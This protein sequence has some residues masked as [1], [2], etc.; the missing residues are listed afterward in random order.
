MKVK[1]GKLLPDGRVRHI[2]ISSVEERKIAFMLKTFYS[3]DRQLDALLELGNLVYIG[4]SPC[5]KFGGINDGLHCY[6]EIR[7]NKKSLNKHGAQITNNKET[8]LNPKENCFFFENGKWTVQLQE[9][10]TLSQLTVYSVKDKDFSREWISGLTWRQ[11]LQKSGEE[12]K[13]YYLFNKKNKLVASILKSQ[14]Q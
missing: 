13:S 12:N 6:A 3:N 2:E 11:L 10:D 7:D 14:L 9:K 5:G 1:I 8:F 4:S